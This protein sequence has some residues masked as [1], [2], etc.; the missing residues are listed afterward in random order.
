MANSETRTDGPSSLTAEVSKSTVKMVLWLLT[1]VT[2]RQQVAGQSVQLHRF[3]FK[4]PV[5]QDQEHLAVIQFYLLVPPGQ[6]YCS[7][8]SYPTVAVL[9]NDS[10]N[11]DNDIN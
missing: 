6:M 1:A 9:D 10:D 11:P 8:P 5:S 4:K 7:P 2:R 3:V